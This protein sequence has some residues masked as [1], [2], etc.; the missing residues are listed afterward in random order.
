MTSLTEKDVE[1]DDDDEVPET[2]SKKAKTPQSRTV[3]KTASEKSNRQ[4]TKEPRGPCTPKAN[5][6][7]EHQTAQ[8]QAGT[9]TED[10]GMGDDEYAELEAEIDAELEAEPNAMPQADINAMP[11]ADLN[12]IAEVG[13]DNEL[14]AGLNN[15]EGFS[16]CDEMRDLFFEDE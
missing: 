10:N 8:S 5:P 2:P 9:P 3:T 7:T 6:L 16:D 11:Q 15:S 1:A 14:S 12:G 13:E 4:P